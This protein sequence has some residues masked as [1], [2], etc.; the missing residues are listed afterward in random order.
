[1]TWFTDW[2]FFEGFVVTALIFILVLT[3]WKK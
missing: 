2:G 3:I 1:M